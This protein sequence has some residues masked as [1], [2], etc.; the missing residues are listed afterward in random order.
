MSRELV[1]AMKSL[2]TMKVTVTLTWPSAWAGVTTS[3]IGERGGMTRRFGARA[4][5][6]L[7]CE[8]MDVR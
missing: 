7:G 8:G 6:R 2:P 1:E 5:D 3:M 4:A